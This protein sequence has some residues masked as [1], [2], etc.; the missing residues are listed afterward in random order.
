MCSNL[1]GTNP[2]AAGQPADAVQEKVDAATKNALNVAEAN[3]S[4]AQQT[5][6]KVKDQIPEGQA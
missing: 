3:R 6:D 1:G 5:L 2:G 4:D